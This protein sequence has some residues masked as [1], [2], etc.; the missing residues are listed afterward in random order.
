MKR[1]WFYLMISILIFTSCVKPKE[2]SSTLKVTNEKLQGLWKFIKIH[3]N[4]QSDSNHNNDI[5]FFDNYWYELDYPICYNFFNKFKYSLKADSLIRYASNGVFKYQLDLNGDT[6]ILSYNYD[7]KDLFEMR[8]FIKTS[9]D[10][11]KLEEILKHG[12]NPDTLRGVFKYYTAYNSDDLEATDLAKIKAECFIIDTI[13][14]SPMNKKN[15]EIYGDTLIY[16]F[17]K[18]KYFYKIEQINCNSCYFSDIHLSYLFGG[19]ERKYNMAYN[20]IK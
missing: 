20:K 9:Y 12:F 6:L 3:H 18:I 15:F 5:F 7:S 17:R 10:S 13:D 8:Y 11:V 14:L 16:S 19:C 4:T 2:K 1:H